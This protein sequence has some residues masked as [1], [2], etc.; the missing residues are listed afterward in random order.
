LG[1]LI[2][3]PADARLCNG[4]ADFLDLSH[5]FKQS[6]LKFGEGVAD[7]CQISGGVAAKRRRFQTLLNLLNFW[8]QPTY[9]VPHNFFTH[10]ARGVA[11]QLLD[12]LRE[13]AAQVDHGGL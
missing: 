10:S 8:G 2:D 6:A 1:R 4:C 12:K 3:D 9:D 5:T 7:G 11:G 13:I